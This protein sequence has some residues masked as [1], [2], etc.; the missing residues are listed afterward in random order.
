MLEKMYKKH[1]LICDKCEV[2][3]TFDDF[4]EAIEF[5]KEMKWK[6]I[7]L[8]KENIWM[9]LCPDCKEK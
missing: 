8:N 6:S 4:I 5:K 7:F 3:Y 2:T 1:I 9:D